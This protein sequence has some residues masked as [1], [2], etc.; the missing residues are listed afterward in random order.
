VALFK[1]AQEN[2]EL[3]ERASVVVTRRV[4]RDVR[5]PVWWLME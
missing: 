2:G 5:H 4:R 3:K 1:S